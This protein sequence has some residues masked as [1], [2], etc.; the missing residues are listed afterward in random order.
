MKTITWISA[1][2]LIVAT[3]SMADVK[4]TEEMTFEVKP[5]ARISVENINGDIRVTGGGERVKVL[6]HK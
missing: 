4:E 5:G 1:A 3:S 6:A 2:L